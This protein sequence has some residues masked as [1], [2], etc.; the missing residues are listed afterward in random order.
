MARFR[1]FVEE[2]DAK[3]GKARRKAE[4]EAAA[5]AHAREELAEVAVALAREAA[6]CEAA[7]A[8]AGGLR[9]H[10]LFL[11]EVCDAWVASGGG[12][13]AEMA[14]GR[15]EAIRGLMAR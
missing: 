2:N 15:A 12:G 14:G 6:A 4:V 1:G 3:A 8:E 10:T 5:A 11:G 9:V 13:Q 7:E